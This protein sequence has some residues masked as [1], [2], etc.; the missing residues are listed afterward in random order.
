MDATVS[1]LSRREFLGSGAA[2]ALLSGLGCAASTS[3][4]L[5]REIVDPGE[6]VSTV[7]I[8]PQSGAAVDLLKGQRLKVITPE[9]EQV[10][11]LFAFVRSAP[12]EHLCP[13]T[14]ATR[15]RRLY[16]EV[17]QPFY[18]NKRRPL[19]MLRDDTVG[20][21]DL[22]YPACDK[23]MYESWGEPLHPSCRGN[24]EAALR[25][26]GFTPDGYAEPHNLFQN[27]PVTDLEGHLEVR[28][29]PA[30]PGDYVLLEA[31]D[32][33]VVVATACAVDRGV[34]NGDRPKAI[35]LEI[36]A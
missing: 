16:P 2:A 9:G 12:D 29:S 4:P 31:L 17:G 13:R 22:L 24:L 15:Q 27:S 33:L 18:S 25:E 8:P 26:I 19:L 6:L 34:L 32:D 11:D 21:H 36:Y 7:V 14:T 10:S 20:V 28:R 5:R 1:S 35:L 30:K 23:Y 3:R